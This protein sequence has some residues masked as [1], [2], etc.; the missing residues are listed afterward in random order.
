MIQEILKYL[1][2]IF[3]II[4]LVRMTALLVGSDI[5]SLKSYLEN[6][7]AQK[8]KTKYRP[9]VSVVIPA[10]N[11]EKNII[12]A[13]EAVFQSTYPKYKY[14][15]VVVDDG[16]TDRTYK[17]INNFKKKNPRGN[18]KIIR[19]KNA[20]KAN[21]LNN[22][23]KSHTK[24]ELIMCLDADSY[25]DKNALENAVKYFKNKNIAALGANVRI[26]EDSSFLNLIQKFEY[27]V[28]SRMKRAH[29]TFNIEY[30]I[31]GIGSVFRRS[32]LKKVAYYDTDTVTEDI[33]LTL[34]IIGLGNKKYQVVYGA[35]V[36]A[37]TEGVQSIKGL[38]N[39]RFR[40]KWGRAQT[41]LKNKHLF[42]NTDRKYSKP[43]TFL[44]LPFA[45]YG[46]LSFLFE[47]VIITFIIFISIKFLDITTLI[48]AFLVI[49]LYISFNILGEDT[50]P[51][52]TRLKLLL[53][54]PT[55]YIYFYIISFA[56]YVALI[57]A[58]TKIYKVK[59]SLEDKS[60]N[61]EHVQRS[62]T[63]SLASA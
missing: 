48:S 44:Y 27:L 4:N 45:I 7:K 31:G 38:I 29:T 51:L 11:E 25:L 53:I 39:Q 57:K 15:I 32:V 30:I 9:F 56:E 16:S 55:M 24:G 46:D 36:I 43:L 62:G 58:L 34:K 61:W 26:L 35:D 20:G 19:Q 8:K 12:Q 59:D 33:D 10:Y 42:F 23:I 21:A 50:L 47:P 14:E 3:G 6:E 28:C 40:W 2:I 18:L 37:Y 1:I 5:Y 13:V 17:L 54:A 49:A 63:S 52:N 41:F 22:A 60:C